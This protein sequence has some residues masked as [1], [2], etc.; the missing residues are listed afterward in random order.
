MFA[1]E[2]FASRAEVGGTLYR[3]TAVLHEMIRGEAPETFLQK[4]IP[5]ASDEEISLTG[6]SV[7]P[8]SCRPG[9][10]AGVGGFTCPI[11][12][13]QSGVVATQIGSGRC[14]QG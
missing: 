11:T 13:L 14:M 7:E 12:M 10:F 4:L 6:F 3:V 8:S 1:P 2:R 5:I 9:N